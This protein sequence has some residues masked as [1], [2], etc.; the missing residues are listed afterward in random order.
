MV[1]VGYVEVVV[2][3][4]L[5]V[6]PIYLILNNILLLMLVPFSFLPIFTPSSFSLQRLILFKFNVKI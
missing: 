4:K 2:L 3:L 6:G 1:V 5:L